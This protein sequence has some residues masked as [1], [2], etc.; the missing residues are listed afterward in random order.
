MAESSAAAMLSGGNECRVSMVYDDDG[1]DA[2]I[3][4]LG[5]AWLSGAVVQRWWMRGFTFQMEDYFVLCLMF[6]VCGI[7]SLS[8]PDMY[9]TFF[10][11][12][13]F[14]VT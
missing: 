11:D 5:F 3:P 7:F 10:S 1:D 13:R 8:L 14:V 4:L 9:W 12:C 6:D 2:M